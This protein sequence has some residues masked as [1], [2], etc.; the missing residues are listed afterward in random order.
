MA[1]ENRYAHL[2]DSALAVMARFFISSPKLATGTALEALAMW[3]KLAFAY[4]AE[5][6]STT[7]TR[8]FESQNTVGYLSHAT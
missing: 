7:C 8:F 3:R 2:V 4:V 6:Y 1:R 5:T